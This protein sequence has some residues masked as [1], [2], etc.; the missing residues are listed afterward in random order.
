M[1]SNC[2][3]FPKDYSTI[4]VIAAVLGTS[5]YHP[6]AWYLNLFSL[7]V[8]LFYLCFSAWSY[9]YNI[10]FKELLSLTLELLMKERWYIHTLWYAIL[11]SPISVYFIVYF[12]VAYAK[13]KDY[14]EVYIALMRRFQSWWLTENIKQNVSNIYWGHYFLRKKERMTQ[15]SSEDIK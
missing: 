8:I 11:F 13:R 12:P 14:Q 1:E 2:L 10:W 5:V 9:T 3:N 6:S 4:I 15:N 7:C